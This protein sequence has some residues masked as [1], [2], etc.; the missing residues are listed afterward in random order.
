MSVVTAGAGSPFSF[1]H[2]LYPGD[3]YRMTLRYQVTIQPLGCRH[4]LGPGVAVVK[5]SRR[6]VHREVGG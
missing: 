6:G 3:R 1:V 2:R 5:Q 4:P